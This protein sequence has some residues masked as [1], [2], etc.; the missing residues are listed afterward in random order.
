MKDLT[1]LSAIPVPAPRPDEL[2]AID[3]F[4]EQVSFLGLKRL[5]GAADHSKAGERHAGLAASNEREREAAR[6]I[7][8]SLT[9]QHLHD[10]PLTTEEGQIDEVMRVNYDI[11]HEAFASIADLTLGELKNRL[12]RARG[13]EIRR[14]VVRKS[15]RKTT[16]GPFTPQNRPRRKATPRSHSLKMRTEPRM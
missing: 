12:L 9:L 6:S 4:G 14:I 2:Y 8:A 13:S 11:N 1:P 3:A 7:L 15:G 10:R 5:L 16:P